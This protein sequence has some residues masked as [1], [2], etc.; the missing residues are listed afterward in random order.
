MRRGAR[1]GG[2]LVCDPA[3]PKP[4]P[5]AGACLSSP[6]RRAT[7][8]ARCSCARAGI[9]CVRKAGRRTRR[10]RERERERDGGAD[11]RRRH[12]LRG[13]NDSSGAPKVERGES[14]NSRGAA[15]ATHPQAACPAVRGTSAATTCERAGGRPPKRKKVS[16]CDGSMREPNGSSS[17][18]RHERRSRAR[19]GGRRTCLSCSA[20]R[21]RCTTA[22]AKGK[23]RAAPH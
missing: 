19:S 1:C 4:L 13:S 15:G 10:G 21:R 11:G 16:A 6:N 20:L 12:R 18:G 2:S 3:P 14:L 7:S 8:A 22:M 9:A 23:T 5:R 17:S